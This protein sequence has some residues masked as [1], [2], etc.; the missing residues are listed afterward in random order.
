MHMKIDDGKILGVHLKDL[1]ILRIHDRLFH[2]LSYTIV[3]QRLDHDVLKEHLAA[4][5]MA[6]Q[7]KRAPGQNTPWAFLMLDGRGRFDIVN[8]KRAVDLDPDALALDNNVDV[9]PLVV[10]DD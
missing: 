6:L 1:S 3:R 8:Q 7:R 2:R 4:F 10:L 5:V 9:E